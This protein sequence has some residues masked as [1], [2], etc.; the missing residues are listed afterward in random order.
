LN[1]GDASFPSL[2]ALFSGIRF[3][4]FLLAVCATAT[5]VVRAQEQPFVRIGK[6][7]AHPVRILARYS[8]D[9]APQGLRAT[10][11]S[12]G[13]HVVRE[14]KLI[15]GLIVLGDGAA[16]RVALQGKGAA[17]PDTLVEKIRTLRDSGLFTYVQPDYVIRSY[18]APGDTRFGDG[19]LWG[20]RNIGNQNGQPGMDIN[21]VNAWDL[22]TGSTNVIVAVTDSGIRFTHQELA[23]QMWRNPGEFPDNHADD[24]NDGYVDDL[25]GIDVTSPPGAAPVDLAGHGTHVAGTIGAAAND[26]HDHVGVA[27]KVRLMACRFLNADGFGFTDGAIE[28]IEYA[29]AHGARIINASWGGGPFAPALFDAIAAARAHGILFVAAAG[30]EANDNDLSPAYP[31]SYQLD[32]V[33]SVAAYDRFG[34]IASF[35]NFGRRSVHIGAPGVDIFSCGADSDSDYKIFS[36]TSMAAPHVSGVAA[37]IAAANPGI[38]V[39]EMRDR[40]LTSARPMPSLAGKT[41]SGGGLDAFAALSSA[42]DG[43]LSVSI[44]PPSGIEIAAGKL[45]PIQVTVTD[46]TVVTNARVSL[47]IEGQPSELLLRNDGVAPDSVKG[48]ATYAA[49]LQLPGAAGTATLSF[50]VTAPGKTQFVAQ[51]AYTLLA[52]PV[53]D[54]FADAITLPPEGGIFL[55]TSKLAS[56][57][58]GEPFHA[59]VVSADG[60]LWWKWTPAVSTTVVVDTAGSS[61]DTVVA[62]YTNSTLRT[63]AL[64]A[65][66]DDAPAVGSRPSKPQG[67]V[68]FDAIAGTE[69]R[70]A[71]AGYS[72][73]ERGLVRLRVETNGEADT[74]APTVTVTSP[75]SGLFIAD[76]PNG[77]LVVT[78]SV[79]DP[80]PN[81]SGIKEVLIKVNE[82]IARAVSG[83]ENWSS[84][85][86]LRL[87]RN[88]FQVTV[89][90]YAGN[91]TASRPVTVTY[92]PVLSPNDLLANA[93][94]LP[95]VSGSVS[96]DNSQA[97]VEPG[98]PLHAGNASGKSIWWNYRPTAD[99]F[100]AVTATNATF[101]V[102]LAAYVGNDV[103]SLVPAASTASGSPPAGGA[104]RLEFG[105][106]AGR[107][108]RLAAD[109]GN[110]TFGTLELL[111]AFRPAAV[112][113]V[114]VSAGDGGT[115]GPAYGVY[116]TGTR[117][118]LRATPLPNFEF[119][120]WTGSFESDKNPLEIDL[121]SDLEFTALF[122]PHQ[123]SDGF[124]SGDFTALNWSNPGP[125][126][127]LVQRDVVEAGQFAVRSGPI[128]DGQSTSL[129]LVASL[130]EGRGGFMLK[131]SS[132]QGFDVLTF[133]TNG[134]RAGRWS[135]EVPWTEFTFPVAAGTNTFEWRYSK[136]PS[137]S[138]EGLDAAF[139]DSIELPLRIPPDALAPA[140]LTISIDPGGAFL[141]R[142]TGQPNQTYVLL[143]SD[144]LQS[145]RPVS[146][147]TA[148][149]GVIRYLDPKNAGAT[150]RYYRAVVP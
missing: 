95:G 126:P 108:Y 2:S 133:L 124:E 110:Q 129:K 125:V 15:P 78:G 83:L 88:V 4:S 9:A 137:K 31:A 53:N 68:Q 26:G 145:W 109:G 138:S 132:E 49:N 114:S 86:L 130:R 111:Y 41:S 27:W 107:V 63:L 123:V 97:G 8:G 57:E 13:L 92:R 39:T 29:T 17:F 148:L 66:N 131:V 7:D 20:L 76:A 47:R 59:Q 1:K 136:D 71:V 60:S 91:I 35:S 33:I 75:L 115:A 99:G 142:A 40:L 32:N 50:S 139:L 42:P 93:A 45:L 82:E 84:T 11:S 118:A 87:G 128:T 72:D 85:N 3:L 69:Y 36:G 46:G 94:E 79:S 73:G 14:S 19:V 101:S 122:H 18:L 28:C 34:K 98:E 89:S 51:V 16:G 6:H 12:V 23:A 106:K 30:N 44:E 103:G 25:Y 54:N 100:L 141:V 104:V 38:S 150:Q 81:S 5:L 67:L 48:D 119:E 143:A 146:T 120:R 96:G 113:Q 90:D 135:G 24:D 147:N 43:I 80:A 55:A 121:N 77:R 64:V 116:A 10:L 140:R 105:V 134:V 62:V 112:A 149:F 74:V 37:L 102:V 22:T 61:F 127:W 144:D 21:A 117:L 52:R 56:E 65:A 70:I 58:P